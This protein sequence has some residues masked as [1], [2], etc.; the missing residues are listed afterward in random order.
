LK[1]QEAFELLEI[2]HC[3]TTRTVSRKS[4]VITGSVIL[5]QGLLKSYLE[6]LNL[7]IMNIMEVDLLISPI[8]TTTKV[9]G[10]CFEL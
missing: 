6:W 4:L 10:Y 1:S 5:S 7:S 8:I 3:C 2:G 9:L